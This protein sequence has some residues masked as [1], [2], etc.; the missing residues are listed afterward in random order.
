MPVPIIND[1]IFSKQT[2]EHNFNTVYRD[3]LKN[4]NLTQ[5]NLTAQLY[6]KNYIQESLR[7]LRE[8]AKEHEA[9]LRNQICNQ[10]VASTTVTSLNS[11]NRNLKIVKIQTNKKNNLMLKQLTFKKPQQN[12]IAK[13]TELLIVKPTVTNKCKLRDQSN[14]MLVKQIS[15]TNKKPHIVRINRP[16]SDK[17]KLLKRGGQDI[18]KV[19]SGNY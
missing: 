13:S 5:Q 19:Q 9:K 2:A 7:F 8:K 1:F 6:F 3:M 15:C 18:E 14:K 11:N 16:H 17:P 10:S 4:K 12:K